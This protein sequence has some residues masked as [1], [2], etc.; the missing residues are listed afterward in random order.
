MDDESYKEIIEWK[1]E[2]EVQD[3]KRKTQE[4]GILSKEELRFS[5]R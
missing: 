3:S 4:E 5:N 2:Q 1:K